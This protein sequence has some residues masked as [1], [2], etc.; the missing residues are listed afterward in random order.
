MVY[1]CGLLE[2]RLQAAST[3]S[4]SKYADDENE[5]P[6][7]HTSAQ[8]P[9]GSLSPEVPGGLGVR[10]VAIGKYYPPRARGAAVVG[11]PARYRW[12]AKA[13]TPTR[14]HSVQVP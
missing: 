1:Y 4:D 8:V 2:Y 13:G 12:P 10:G 5:N 7:A 11:S 3:R 14:A 9:S 6:L